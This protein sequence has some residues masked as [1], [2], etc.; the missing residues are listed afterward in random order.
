M[1]PAGG[2]PALGAQN[3]QKPLSSKNGDLFERV[4]FE[5]WLKEGPKQQVR[6]QTQAEYLGL[7]GYQRQLVGIEAYVD[8][9]ELLK[10]PRDRQLILL[11][12]LTDSSGRRYRSARTLELNALKAVPNGGRHELQ[13]FDWKAFALPGDYQVAMA[14]YHAD[15]GEHNLVQRRLRVPAIH[16]D[17]LAN[18]WR[19]LPGVEFWAPTSV[20]DI[21]FF[22]RPEFED[23]LDLP[24]V[25][26]RPVHMEIMVDLA[27]S[28]LF[29]GSDLLYNRYLSAVLPTMKIFSQ[30]QVKNG[31]TDVSVLDLAR[32]EVRFRQENAQPLDWESMKRALVRNGAAVVSVEALSPK[33]KGPALIKEEL[34]RRLTAGSEGDEAGAEPLRVFVLISSPLGLY[35]FAGLKSSLMP[36]NCSCVVYYLE[37]D[38][39]R[40]P[41]M[42]GAIGNVKKM[43]R[44]LPVHAFEAH[45]AD[46]VRKALAVILRDVRE[47]A[48]R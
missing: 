33:H 1:F 12:Q 47:A 18:S 29:H 37:Y 40:R 21:D 41:G 32:R 10:R 14:L 9:P 2:T 31:T 19:G 15:T 42:Y 27:A 24:L 45:S 3:P 34:T 8:L 23:T 28:D 25:T 35:S 13:R 46:A 7:S 48:D 22:Y 38:S 4:P 16:N 6:W 20:E 44:P 11:L 26:R 39:S 43:L 5:E 17:L 30:I 36:A